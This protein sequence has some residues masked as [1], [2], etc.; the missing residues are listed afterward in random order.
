MNSFL[1]MKEMRNKAQFIGEKLQLQFEKDIG[2]MDERA[3]WQQL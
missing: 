2:Q 3:G 1:M